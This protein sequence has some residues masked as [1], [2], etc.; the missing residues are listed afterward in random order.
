MSTDCTQAKKRTDMK[1]NRWTEKQ[2]KN[3]KKPAPSVVNAGFPDAEYLYFALNVE[4]V[5]QKSSLFPA[6]NNHN[7]INLDIPKPMI[8]FARI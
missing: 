8:L 4:G 6:H 5:T 2:S 7:N 1:T 3:I